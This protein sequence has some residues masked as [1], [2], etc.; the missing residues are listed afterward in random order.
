MMSEKV[1]GPIADAGNTV[2]K[3]LNQ[4]GE[5]QDQVAEFIQDKPIYPILIAVAVG[6]LLGKIV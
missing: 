3:G 5:I 2:Q 1:E 4:A 6:Y